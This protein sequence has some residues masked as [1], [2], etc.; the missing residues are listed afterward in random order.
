[1]TYALAGGADAA[2]FAIDA[3]TGALSFVAA[4][5][6][7]APADADGDNVYEVV[8]SAS[9]GS[10]S[11]TQAVTVAVGNLVDGLTLTGTSAANT[12]TG[13]YEED[14]I[15]G[16][17]GNDTLNGLGGADCARRRRRAGPAHRRRRRRPAD[18]RSQGRR[19]RVRS[20]RRQHAR[21][22][23]PD[24]RL[25]SARRATRST[26][27]RSTPT[28]CSA[29]TRR[30]ASSAARRSPASPASCAPSSRAAIRSCRA[31]SN[32]DGLADFQVVIDP[33]VGLASSDFVLSGSVAQPAAGS[34]QVA[35]TPPLPGRAKGG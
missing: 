29:G 35:T 5:D 8:V 12:L 33:L 16:L 11:D 22:E 21:R 31:T 10:L 20:A 18:R 13:S 23:R 26:F 19:F 7:D 27:R 14:T 9:D 1:M 25:Q 24:S 15:S 2:R 4:P 30:S 3:R 32:G 28:P 6:Y 34:A 17:G